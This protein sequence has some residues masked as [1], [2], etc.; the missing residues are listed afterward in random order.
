MAELVLAILR[1]ALDLALA[2]GVDVRGELTAAEARRV[3]LEVDAAEEAAL[4]GRAAARGGS[5]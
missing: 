4:A 2:H 1:A 5:P 3:D